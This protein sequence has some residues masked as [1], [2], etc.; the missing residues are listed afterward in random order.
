[1][2]VWTGTLNLGKDPESKALNNGSVVVECS[3]AVNQG[4][5]KP[6]MWVK[7]QAWADERQAVGTALMECRKGRR[8]DVTG[9]LHTDVWTNRDGNEVTTI[10]VTAWEIHAWPER[11]QDATP[12]RGHDSA[13]KHHET[14]SRGHSAPDVPFDDSEEPGIPF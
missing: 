9:R 10:I 4:R 3:G 5:N 13:T 8:L 2:S 6:P 12:S 1:M 7:L 14:T 11:Q